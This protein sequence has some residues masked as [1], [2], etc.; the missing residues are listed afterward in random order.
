MSFLPWLKDQRVGHFQHTIHN[1]ISEGGVWGDE[2]KEVPLCQLYE[3]RFG[4]SKPRS[5]CS[6][7]TGFQSFKD[8]FCNFFVPDELAEFVI[9]NEK[10]RT[11]NRHSLP[12][13]SDWIKRIRQNDAAAFE[14][15]FKAYCQPLVDFGRRFVLDKATAESLVQDVFLKI[16]QNRQTLDPTRNIKSYLFTAVRNAALRHLRD[17][18]VK[19]RN[20]ETVRAMHAPVTTPE[21]ELTG[22]DLDESIQ[23][24]IAALPEKCRAIF[25]MNRFDKLTYAEIAEVQNISVKT[26]ETQMGRALKSLRTQLAHFLTI[27]PL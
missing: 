9:S 17:A 25:R 1:A 8:L 5:E 18:G 24:A 16:W 19:Q 27:F 4:L 23:Q 20:E 15:L 11:D 3:F 7:G 21:Q 6:F 13:E 14:K 26:V 2:S 22:K 10:E 12:I